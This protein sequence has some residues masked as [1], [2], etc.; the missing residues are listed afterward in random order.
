MVI[1]WNYVALGSGI[2]MVVSIVASLWP[3]IWVARA[4]PLELLQAT[5]GEH[6]PSH[7]LTLLS[8]GHEGNA[9]QRPTVEHHLE[10]RFHDITEAKPELVAPNVWLSWK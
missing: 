4:E 3:A 1:P 10:L 5:A 6:R 8:P 7:V 9:Q 2:V